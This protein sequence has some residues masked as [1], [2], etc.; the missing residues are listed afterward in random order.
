M[1]LTCNAS[2]VLLCLPPFYMCIF[3]VVVV[4][5]PELPS[6]VVVLEAILPKIFPVRLRCVRLYLFRVGGLF[7]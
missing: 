5:V 6:A 3:A 4:R 7:F 2:L 1:T